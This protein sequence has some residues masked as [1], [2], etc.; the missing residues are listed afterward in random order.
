MFVREKTVNGYTY[1]YLVKRVREKGRTKQRIIPPP[2]TSQ[3]DP[4][5]LI[6]QR[7]FPGFIGPVRELKL[8]RGVPPVDQR[9][10]WTLIGVLTR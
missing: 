5:L 8:H 7:N 9:V 3:G 10:D 4:P 6:R 1:L 2:L